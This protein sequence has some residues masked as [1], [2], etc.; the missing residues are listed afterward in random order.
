MVFLAKEAGLTETLLD[1]RPARW[2]LG[3]RIL[4]GAAVC[5]CM[6]TVVLLRGAGRPAELVQE[7]VSVLPGSDR[8]SYHS[9]PWRQADGGSY[10]LWAESYAR[11]HGDGKLHRSSLAS[12]DAKPN[13]DNKGNGWQKAEFDKWL[14]KQG[15]APDEFWLEHGFPSTGSEYALAMQR[16]GIYSPDELAAFNPRQ[17]LFRSPGCSGRF[18]KGTSSG[19]AYCGWL[20]TWVADS[21]KVD[22]TYPQEKG[23]L[24][25]AEVK[26]RL[27]NVRKGVKNMV[28]SLSGKMVYDD[29]AF[30][31][32]SK[33]P[34]DPDFSACVH[35]IKANKDPVTNS[36][37]DKGPSWHSL[38]KDLW[39]RHADGEPTRGGA[40]LMGQTWDQL[41]SDLWHDEPYKERNGMQS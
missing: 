14:S 10:G 4:L 29:A 15:D 17:E 34:E 22:L 11:K 8:Y 23:K 31:C 32:Y 9:D 3:R 2:G 1:S 18:E 25:P 36:R 28:P 12:A 39:E 19:H 33:Y 40:S 35:A 21:P 27:D 6:T 30:Y 13:K 20:E 26:Q 7:P 5:M 41:T 24:S 16:L 37:I 38:T